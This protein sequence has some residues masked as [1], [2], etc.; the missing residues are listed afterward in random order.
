MAEPAAAPVIKGMT[1]IG[2]STCRA[3][4]KAIRWYLTGKGK[5]LPFNADDNLPH[6]KSCK[7]AFK[8][9]PPQGSPT[10]VRSMK[11]AAGIQS[12]DVKPYYVYRSRGSKSKLW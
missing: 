6:W 9:R 10:G 12:G 8:N 3:C 11:N 5:N 2:A 4:E 1:L 7:Y